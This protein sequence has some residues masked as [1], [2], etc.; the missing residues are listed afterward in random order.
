MQIYDIIID[1]FRQIIYNCHKNKAREAQSRH[2]LS[3][4]SDLKQ[5]L[6]CFMRLIRV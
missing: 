3:I 2:F 5:V 6:A 1:N 4:I